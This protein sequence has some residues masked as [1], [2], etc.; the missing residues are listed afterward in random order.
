MPAD[1]TSI[2]QGYAAD[3][4]Q[5]AGNCLPD[6]PSSGKLRPLSLGDIDRRTRAARQAEQL[7]ADLINDLGGPRAVTAGQRELAQR[8]AVM[9]AL[10]ED[11]EARMLRGDPVDMNGYLAAVNAM[12][13]VVAT[14]GCLE[15]RPRVISR[16]DPLEYAAQ[17]ASA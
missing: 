11:M 4:P 3:G 13:R 1:S 15:R 5:V 6:A 14:L 7:L 12:R 8:A 17:R 9:T 2:A 16:D 10:I